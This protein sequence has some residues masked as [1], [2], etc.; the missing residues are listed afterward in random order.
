MTE[1]DGIAIKFNFWRRL[2][3]TCINSRGGLLAVRCPW[4]IQDRICELHRLVENHNR[5]M[6]RKYLLLP[7]LASCSAAVQISVARSGG[8]ATTNLQ[9][10][11]MEEVCR[12]P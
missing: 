12:V 3:F 11:V 6:L 5:I 2:A 8:N 7:L 1:N 4:S 10:G 9:Y